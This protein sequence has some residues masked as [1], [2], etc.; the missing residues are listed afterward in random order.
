[1]YSFV[2]DPVTILCYKCVEQILKTCFLITDSDAISRFITSKFSCNSE[3]N[4]SEL[5]ENLEEIF[6]RYYMDSDVIRRVKS[7]ATCHGVIALS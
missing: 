7:S 6:P 3:A 1:M 2:N 4:A 5:Q